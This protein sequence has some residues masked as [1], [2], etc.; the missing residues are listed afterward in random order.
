MSAFRKFGV[1]MITG[2]LLLVARPLASASY[3][4][5]LGQI[6]QPVRSAEAMSPNIFHHWPSMALVAIDPKIFHH[7]P[8]ETTAI[9]NLD[10]SIFHHWPTVAVAAVDSKIFHH[11]PDGTATVANLDRSIFHHWA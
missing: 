11:W 10:P 7:W 5:G 8:D 3:A 1:S 9:T 4:I 2:A 6:D